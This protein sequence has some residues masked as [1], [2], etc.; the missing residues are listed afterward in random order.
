MNETPPT[1]RARRQLTWS[2]FGRLLGCASLLFLLGPSFARTL[3]PVLEPP[4]DFFQDWASARNLTRG[5]PIYGNLRTAAGDYLQLDLARNLDGFVEINGH[6]PTSVWWALPLAHCEYRTAFLIWDLSSL[7]LVIA[8]LGLIGR[9][10]GYRCSAA[11]CL[12]AV[13]LALLCNPL[14][15]L[16]AQGQFGGVLLFLLTVA[17]VADR[18]GRAVAAGV[19]VGLA[20]AIKL[21]PG[22]MIAYW[23][24]S[25]RRIQ[26]ATATATL[27]VVAAA[28]AAVMGPESFV[29]YAQDVMPGMQYWYDSGLNLSLTGFWHRLFH[30]PNSVFTP[31]VAD[32]QIARIGTA[33]SSLVVLG[34]WGAVVIRLRKSA[35]PDR[36]WTTTILAM[37]LV[38]PLTWDHSL[39]VLAIPLALAWRDSS[40]DAAQRV[41]V[42]FVAAVLWLSPVLVWRFFLG[43]RFG[44]AMLS[45]GESLTL[46]SFPCYAVVV[47]FVVVARQAWNGLAVDGAKSDARSVETNSL[48]RATS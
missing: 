45:P 19:C 10:L 20:A 36:A 29:V 44:R 25:G 42:T 47:L 37:T 18:N 11:T 41:G 48:F 1:P 17:W 31:L 15:Q 4:G 23:L 12:T 35:L 28:T 6:P 7:L 46:F 2:Q 40:A 14:R 32:P 43:D 16:L 9:E 21:Y 26:A 30:G 22:L 5:L 24:L 39:V 27:I 34:I 8:S 3:E 38:S 13:S 33:L